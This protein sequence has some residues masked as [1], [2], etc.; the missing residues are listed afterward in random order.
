MNERIVGLLTRN[1]LPELQSI[2]RRITTGQ[3]CSD[4]YLNAIT[5]IITD[6]KY[7]KNKKKRK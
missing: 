7:L 6:I 5:D 3:F 4:G 1:T 2:K